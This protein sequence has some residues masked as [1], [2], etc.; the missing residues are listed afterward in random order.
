MRS[1]HLVAAAL[2]LFALCAGAA[3]D[4][5]PRDYIPEPLQDGSDNWRINFYVHLDP[6]FGNGTRLVEFDSLSLTDITPG[7]RLLIGFA[8]SAPNADADPFGM[9]APDAYHSDRTFL[10][11]LGDPSGGPSGT[12]NDPRK[13]TPIAIS[14]PLAHA[15]WAGGVTSFTAS[16]ARFLFSDGADANTSNGGL[17]ALFGAA[18]VPFDDTVHVQGMFI[19]DTQFQFSVNFDA[20]AFPEPASAALVVVA[21]LGLFVRRHRG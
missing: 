18:V 20:T 2:T 15:N 1:D 19:T 4:T 3:A 17:G 12:E 10:N 14:M 16:G 21:A 6:A 8:S 9:A 5:F 13:F 7:H 11:I